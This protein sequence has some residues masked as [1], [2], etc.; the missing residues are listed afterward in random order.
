MISL[1][2]IVRYVMR[3]LICFSVCKSSHKSPVSSTRIMSELTVDGNNVCS[4]SMSAMNNSACSLIYC[5]FTQC[6]M[7]S[8]KD[9]CRFTSFS[10]IIP[11]WV[12]ALDEHLDC[13]EFIIMHSCLTFYLVISGCNLNHALN[14]K[15][16]M[17]ISAPKYFFIRTLWD[18]RPPEITD[19]LNEATSC[20]LCTSPLAR[21]DHRLNFSGKHSAML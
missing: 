10:S 3:M 6:V 12:P 5:L 11:W 18:Y 17:F 9:N 20:E 15:L 7:I 1:N 4:M 2:V 19:P 21:L 14:W 8:S 13:M 16:A